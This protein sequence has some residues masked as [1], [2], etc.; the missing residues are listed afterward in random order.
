MIG[1]S[2]AAAF[3]EGCFPTGEAKGA[4]GAG[5]SIPCNIGPAPSRHGMFTIICWS[6]KAR[7][8]YALE[9]VIV[10]RGAVVK[11]QRDQLGLIVRNAD[12]ESIA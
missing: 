1:D 6:T 7:T 3:G 5:S 11:R 2:H 8:D 9:G 12:T 10:I 4:P